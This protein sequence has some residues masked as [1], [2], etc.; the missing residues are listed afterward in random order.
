MVTGRRIA[1]ALGK[2]GPE[3]RG[4]LEVEGA[5]TPDVFFMPSAGIAEGLLAGTTQDRI[6]IDGTGVSDLEHVVA[7]ELVHWYVP[8]SVFAAL[9][10][11]AEEGLAS[12]IA[13]SMFP[14]ALERMRAE[15]SWRQQPL[16]ASYLYLDADGWYQL[17]PEERQAL[18]GRAL[19]VVSALGVEALRHLCEAGDAS[20]ARIV[21]LSGVL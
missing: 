7:H 17:E 9:P 19:D 2:Y 20:V 6:I 4:I 16:L 5:P 12:H 14:P 3:I 10:Y 1:R 11:F 21:E 8:H 15:G 18:A 13:L